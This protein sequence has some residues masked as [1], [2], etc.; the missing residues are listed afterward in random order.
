MQLAPVQGGVRESENLRSE[1]GV[2]GLRS[3]VWDWWGEISGLGINDYIARG[4]VKD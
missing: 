1:A 2:S 4:K 3:R